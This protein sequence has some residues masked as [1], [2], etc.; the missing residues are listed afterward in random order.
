MTEFID[1]VTMGSIWAY[2]VSGM[3]IEWHGSFEYTTFHDPIGGFDFC[4]YDTVWLTHFE[5]TCH[6]GLISLA[7]V[8]VGVPQAGRH[9]H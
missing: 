9:V 3:S 8:I 7:S 5:L 6:S 4:T 1:G 2:G